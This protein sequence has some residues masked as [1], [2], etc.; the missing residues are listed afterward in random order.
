MEPLL[1]LSVTSY[2]GTV[3]D[4]TRTYPTNPHLLLLFLL[5]RLLLVD[6]RPCC[7]TIASV[8]LRRGA[9]SSTVVPGSSELAC[10]CLLH[11][12]GTHVTK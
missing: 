2:G 12:D 4:F 9:G 1:T 10:L 5:R 11:L 6:C 3:A 7:T 8:V